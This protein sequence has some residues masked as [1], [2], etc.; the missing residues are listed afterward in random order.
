MASHVYE[1]LGTRFRV[2]TSEP[3]IIDGV[4]GLLRPF[5]KDDSLPVRAR[6]TY[7]LVNAERVEGRSNGFLV[8]RDCSAVSSGND[9]AELIGSLFTSLN[10][11]AVEGCEHFA[12][13]AG[14]VAF[15]GRAVAFPAESGQGKSTLTAAALRSGFD[16]LS[17]EAICVDIETG[18][19]VPYPKPIG[20]SPWSRQAVGV[21]EGDL[22]FAADSGEGFVTAEQ[23]GAAIAGSGSTLSDIVIAEYGQKPTTLSEVPGSEAMHTLLKMSFN[24][25]KFGAESFYLASR[26]ANGSRAWRLSY[27]D[28]LEAGRLLR[29]RLG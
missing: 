21:V 4:A 8:Y 17:D 29:D 28:P 18:G 16:Y 26:L 22:T 27:D 12:A 20:L 25:Y 9:H 3:G 10:R 7:R 24:H 13:H 5:R 1:M 23:L 15:N 19:L 2:E 6:H 14:V 11:A